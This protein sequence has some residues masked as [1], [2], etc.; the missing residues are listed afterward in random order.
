MPWQ[1]SKLCLSL[2]PESLDQLWKFLEHSGKADIIELRLDHLGMIPFKEVHKRIGKPL[3]ITLRLP[4]EGGFWR[5]TETERV[6]IF[7]Q[8]AHDKVDFL[9]IEWKTASNLLRDLQLSSKT[10]II[11]SHHVRANGTEQLR[12]VFKTMQQIE[13]DIYKLVYWAD[14]LNDNLITLQLLE[15]ARKEGVRCVIHAMGEAGQPSRLL[16]AIRGNNW[17]YVSLA[18]SAPT[19]EGQISLDIAQ[20][21][22][23]LNEK[24]Q[25]TCIIG[26]LGYPLAQ[27]RGWQF[28]NRLIQF[29]KKHPEIYGE[30]IQDFIY[31]NFP[32]EDFDQFWPQWAGIID[33][34]SVTI[35][36][37]KSVV[38]RLD[39][40]SPTVEKSGVCNTILKRN[41]FWWGFNTDM[42]AI[43]D[44]LN[45]SGCK[46]FRGALV[47]GTGAT[48]CSV[49]TALQE[50]NV[51]DIFLSGR[52]KTKGLQLAN[53]FSIDF[54]SEQDLR[55]VHPD[56]IIQTT[57]LGMVP[58]TEDIPPLSHL[59]TKAKLVL[60]VVH[61]PPLTRFLREAQAAN[62][63]IISGEQMYLRQA[64]YQFHLFSGIALPQSVFEDVWNCQVNK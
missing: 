21:I 34:L 29:V 26:L 12:E 57:P 42:L 22:Y 15:E 52:N 63:Q 27:S 30:K 14:H 5:G 4:A 10:S 53:T 25:D 44:L 23:G 28:H 11:I 3:I 9:D 50:L 2:L 47:Y 17:S 55:K 16:G 38:D 64:A 48:A 36:H 37:K 18:E 13:A 51:Q 59:L 54:I 46:L 40:A 49:I 6:R 45:E 20:E 19:A 62:C 32:E 61:N 7:Q 56:V 41:N 24:S 60:D 58:H 35:P 33:G 8:A 39:F 31:I 43:Y 1:P